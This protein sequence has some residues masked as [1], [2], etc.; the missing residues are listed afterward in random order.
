MDLFFGEFRLACGR[1]SRLLFQ[2]QPAR[3]RDQICNFEGLYQ[4]RDVVGLQED[5]FIAEFSSIG[6]GEQDMAFHRR[7][8]FFEPLAGF[9]DAEKG[10]SERIKANG[11]SDAG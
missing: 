4:V 1:R 7:T 9:L 2:Q 3:L 11:A 8:I 5:A 6:E 10:H